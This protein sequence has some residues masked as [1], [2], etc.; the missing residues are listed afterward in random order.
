MA[1]TD[2]FVKAGWEVDPVFR[3]SL[4]EARFILGLWTCCF[5]YTVSYCYLNGYLSHEPLPSAIGPAV[6]S[7]LG[8]LESLNRDPETLTYPFGLGIPDWVF[9]GIAVPWFI[10]IVASFWYGL[11]MFAEDDLSVGE[12]TDD[13]STDAA[14]SAKGTS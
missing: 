14:A 3:N 6:G 12:A 10:C 8:P 4:H 1:E 2:D 7:W 11:F 9:Y 5:F 13:I